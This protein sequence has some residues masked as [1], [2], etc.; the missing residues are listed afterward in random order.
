MHLLPLLKL[1]LKDWGSDSGR[2]VAEERAVDLIVTG[3]QQPAKCFCWVLYLVPGPGQ[4][5]TFRA[6]E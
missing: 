1:D 5:K 6:F 4:I 2:V 3:P